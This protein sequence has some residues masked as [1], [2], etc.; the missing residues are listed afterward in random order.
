MKRRE[1]G[2]ERGKE[3]S[4]EREKSREDD[5]ENK[6]LNIWNGKP[7]VGIRITN[8]SEVK[9]I[10]GLGVCEGRSAHGAKRYR[11][12]LAYFN[13]SVH[14]RL[15]G[16]CGHPSAVRRL[17]RLCAPGRHDGDD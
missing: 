3:A 1:G 14:L 5:D 8:V 17:S 4:R 11:Q 6:K 7:R 10:S 12:E 2:K 16:E 15:D 13:I 9:L